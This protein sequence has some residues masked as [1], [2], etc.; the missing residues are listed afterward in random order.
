MPDPVPAV[1]TTVPTQQ[2]PSP[3]GSAPPSS[4]PDTKAND[5]YDPQWL[6][7]LDDRRRT[8]LRKFFEA[9]PIH[10]EHKT[11][12]DEISRRQAWGNLSKDQIASMTDATHAFDEYKSLVLD[13]GIAT[14]D[15]IE[16]AQTPRELRLLL[17]GRTAQKPQGQQANTATEG[18]PFTA[19]LNQ[20]AKDNGLRLVPD[21]KAAP[22]QTEPIATGGTPAFRQITK[23]NI[24]QMFNEGKVTREEYRLFRNGGSYDGPLPA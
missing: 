23:D 20:W 12:K 24:D 22:A 14:K 18:D 1:V 17:R 11:L 16:L 9:D 15:D 8:D 5:G 6:A 7:K 21:P 13:L 3:V 4:A 2:Q 19:R 10:T